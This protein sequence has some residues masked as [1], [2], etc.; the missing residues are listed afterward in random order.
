MGFM[1]SV[2]K[3]VRA[4]TGPGGGAIFFPASLRF[5]HDVNAMG[6]GTKREIEVFIGAMV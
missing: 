2:P 6:P 4:V 1:A 5:L 3:T